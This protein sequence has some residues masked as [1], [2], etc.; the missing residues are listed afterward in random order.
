MKKEKEIVSHLTKE[1]LEIFNNLQNEEVK[2]DLKIYYEQLQTLAATA[3]KNTHYDGLDEWSKEVYS[4]I[5]KM[6][7]K[8]EFKNG[9]PEE[10][11][12]NINASFWLSIYDVLSNICYS[13]YLET[14]V[15]SHHSSAFARNEAM[16]KEL[17]VLINKI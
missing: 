14:K 4:F 8:Y 13:P 3:I 17:E 10:N 7:A 12:K 2:K 5:H 15:P 16:I 6:L 9:E 1:T 11:K